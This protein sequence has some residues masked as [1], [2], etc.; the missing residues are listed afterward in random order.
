MNL[1]P[2]DDAALI[3][4]VTATRVERVLMDHRGVRFELDIIGLETWRWTI[5]TDIPRGFRMIGQFR[6]KRDAAIAHCLSTIDG[7]LDSDAGA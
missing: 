1:I 2:R 4:P 6:G 5:H 7:H 3:T